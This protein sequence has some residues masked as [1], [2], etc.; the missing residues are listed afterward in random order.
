MEP[1]S[2]L[3]QAQVRFEVRDL[4]KDVGVVGATQALYEMLVYANILCEV[5]IEEGEKGVEPK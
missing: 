2:E 4:I 3:E 5:I 1:V